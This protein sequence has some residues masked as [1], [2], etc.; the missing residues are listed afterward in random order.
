MHIPDGFLAPQTY[1]PAWGLAAVAWYWA[2]RGLRD[3]LDASSVPRLAMLT[4]LVYA[5]GLIMIPLPGGTSGHVLGVALLAL[6][7]GTRTAFL[8][9]SLVLL[10]QSL[11]LGAGGITALGLNALSM[12]L[13]GAATAVWVSRW[14]MPWAPAFAVGAAAFASVLAQA[15]AI[16]VALGLQP[17]LGHSETGSPLFFP[18][19]LE[20]TLPAVLLPHL[21]IGSAEALLTVALW[22]HAQKRGWTRQE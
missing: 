9:Y 14:L 16:A 4:A 21:M 19:G 17:L 15:L 22:R 8:A 1:L 13:L 5:L 20:V 12:G 10:L 6:L 2:G 18:F 3:R 7:H 11:M